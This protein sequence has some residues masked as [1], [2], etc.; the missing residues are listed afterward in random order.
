MIERADRSSSGSGVWVSGVW[1]SSVSVSGVSV[2]GV[3]GSG[4]SGSAPAPVVSGDAPDT[5]ETR[6][7]SWFRVVTVP[8]SVSSCSNSPVD[9][10]RVVQIVEIDVGCS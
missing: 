1:V 5:W 9:V 6:R 4:V 2:S 8:W 7:W 10:L 3:S